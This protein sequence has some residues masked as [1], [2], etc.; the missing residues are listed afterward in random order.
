MVQHKYLASLDQGTSSTRFIVFTA[1]G[2]IVAKH[3]ISLAQR[4]AKHGWVSHSATEMFSAANECIE[5]TVS[6]LKSGGLWSQ[7]CISTIGITNQRETSVAWHRATGDPLCEAIVWLDK[8]TDALVAEMVA[9]ATHADAFK[10]ICGLPI[11]SYFSAVKY[12]W[13][14]RNVASVAEAAKDSNLMFGTVDSWLLYKLTGGVNGGVY[15]TD[16]TNAS[17]TML[18]DIKSVQWDQSMCTFFGIDARCLPEIASSSE[19]YGCIAE[20][21]LKGVTISGIIGD[22]HA[23]L[24]GQLCLKKGDLKNTYGTGCFM[25]LISLT[26]VVQ[27]WRN[28]FIF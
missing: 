14:L 18:M 19:I 7:G 27:Y 17:R 1:C 26:L 3:Q 23:A 24:V 13:M 2:E 10:K 5:K 20:G 22:Q 8:R 9:K 21:S 11:C 25:V 28:T 15:K 16:V 12:C 6:A 4:T